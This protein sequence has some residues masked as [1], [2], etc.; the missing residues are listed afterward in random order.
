[1]Y[2]QFNKKGLECHVLGKYKEAV[3]FFQKSL[4]LNPNDS[5]VWYNLG[6]SLEKLGQYD[7]AIKFIQSLQ[8]NK[9]KN[10]EV[11]NQIGIIYFNSGKFKESKSYFEKALEISPKNTT[12]LQNKNTAHSMIGKKR[13][14][15]IGK[16]IN[17][18]DESIYRRRSSS[19]TISRG[20]T[21]PRG[22]QPKKQNLQDE[23]NRSNS[24]DNTN[25]NEN[26]SLDPTTTTIGEAIKE[27]IETG[28]EVVVEGPQTA[29]ELTGIVENQQDE[30][31]LNTSKENS[32]DKTNLNNIG[33][34]NSKLEVNVIR[35]PN[36]TTS[37]SKE[38]KI[39]LNP[40]ESENGEEATITTVTTI[41]TEG[42]NVE[43][44]TEFTVPLKDKEENIEAENNVQVNPMTTTSSPESILESKDLEKHSPSLEEESSLL[45]PPSQEQPTK[46]INTSNPFIIYTQFWQ[47]IM[48]NWF[49]SYNE[50]LKNLMKMNGFWPG[51]S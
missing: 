20:G 24:N 17:E 23:N 34:D 25:K 46:N 4:E 21:F 41:P 3:I 39:I 22:Y 2:H 13:F 16:V 36:E 32:T 28:K 15:T 9:S 18:I 6:K 8:K 7:N 10:D 44:E 40:K 49:N 27:A 14:I 45:L 38:E 11:L 29:G 30:N 19:G 51:K 1:L 33:K 31:I 48:S 50:F 35:S 12:F 47:H 26:N 43:A 37:L 5:N 42:V